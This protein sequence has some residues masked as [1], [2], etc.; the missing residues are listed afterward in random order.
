MI[1]YQ[2]RFHRRNAI[3]YL[4]LKGDIERSRFLT[5]KT[6]NRKQNTKDRISRAVVVVS[7]KT[8]KS[9]VRRNLIRRRIYAI[10][11]K[12]LHKFKNP[13]DIAFIVSSGEIL[14]LSHNELKEL[15]C[16]LFMQA[17]MYQ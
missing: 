7:K 6:L 10:I 5:L 15:I 13:Y 17:K 16:G 12:E 1:P 4:Y 11:S 2:N 8:L 14:S 3:K 9:A